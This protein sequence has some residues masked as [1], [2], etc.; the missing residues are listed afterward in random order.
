MQEKKTLRA[1]R[2]GS[3][4]RQEST[5]LKDNDLS[6]RSDGLGAYSSKNGSFLDLLANS[7]TLEQSS[8]QSPQDPSGIESPRWLDQQLEAVLDQRRSWRSGFNS[9]LAPAHEPLFKVPVYSPGKKTPDRLDLPEYLVMRQEALNGIKNKAQVIGVENQTEMSRA[10]V[11]EHDSS[12]S[13]SEQESFNFEDFLPNPDLEN[14]K[15]RATPDFERYFGDMTRSLGLDDHNFSELNPIEKQVVMFHYGNTKVME[16]R[17]NAIIENWM[18]Q[19]AWDLDDFV[20]TLNHHR[21]D[22]DQESEAKH[23]EI[24][25]AWQRY[26]VAATQ[27][28]MQ[29]VFKEPAKNNA[30]DLGDLSLSKRAA[31]RP[32]EG[33]MESNQLQRES[34]DVFMSRTSS[35]SLSRTPSDLDLWL[36]PKPSLSNLVI[37]GRQS[38]RHGSGVDPD[39]FAP[40]LASQDGLAVRRAASFSARLSANSKSNPNRLASLKDL[41]LMDAEKLRAEDVQVSAPSSQPP[42]SQFVASGRPCP[43]QPSP[44]SPDLPEVPSALAFRAV[45]G[46]T[47]MAPKRRAS[48][49]DIHG[50]A[51]TQAKYNRCAPKK[52]VESFFDEKKT[53]F[54]F[55]VSV[56]SAGADAVKICE[57]N[58]TIPTAPD[59]SGKFSPSQAANISLP[60]I[61]EEGTKISPFV[62]TPD[63]NRRDI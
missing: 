32:N 25:R 33:K 23:E 39:R 22:S 28:K 6:V 54:G 18:P 1:R 43:S 14:R 17:Q 61:E 48:S 45:K 40:R 11:T 44:L 10:P 47:A 30:T 9:P 7:D 37:M 56:K 16:S 5:P 21:C 60:I 27:S 19:D 34:D 15:P 52:S 8:V 46:I 63:R 50:F 36:Y 31:H 58:S 49:A 4:G 62:S 29:R 26:T 35:P 55:E 38:L 51:T 57:P 2:V 42:G 24:Q 13:E 12:E 20:R 41:V 59:E 3:G 53:L